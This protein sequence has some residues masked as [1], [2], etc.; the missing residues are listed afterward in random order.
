M[1]EDKNEKVVKA[2]N[3]LKEAMQEDPE[4]VMGWHANLSMM[5]YDAIKDDK[6]K[7]SSGNERTDTLR[8]S[9]DMADRF[10][11]SMFYVKLD[12]KYRLI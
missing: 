2:M 11:Q 9:H 3:L 1:S 7:E 10:M 8:I 6:N 4:Y 12:E 5:C